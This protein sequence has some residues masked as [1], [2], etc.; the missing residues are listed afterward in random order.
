MPSPPA[1]LFRACLDLAVAGNAEFVPP[2]DGSG[3]GGFL[4]VR[5]VLF[6]AGPQLL[7][8]PP[9]EFV[10]AVYVAP[11]RPYH[12]AA[13]LD[14]LVLEDFD[15]AAPRGVGSAKLG[16]NYAPVWRHQ[17][18]AKEEG[19]GITL[20]LDSATRRFVEEFSTS[21]FLG[22]KVEEG[23]D[24][25][26]RKVLCV[27]ETPNAIRSATSDSLVR[28]AERDGWTVRREEVCD[29]ISFTLFFTVVILTAAS[30]QIPFDSLSSFDEVLAV[31]TAAAAVP[32]RSIT[33]KSTNEKIVFEGSSGAPGTESEG[34]HLARKMGAIQRGIA[35]DEF[36][37]CCRVEGAAGQ[38]VVEH[39]EKGV[40]E[41]LLWWS[42]K[43][44]Q[45]AYR[46]FPVVF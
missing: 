34:A 39:Q 33:R 3:G 23:K 27:P 44:L 18:R 17:A 16:G 19:F 26:R 35:E 8:A 22:V 14:A 20:H 37:W 15:R 30:A 42:W 46:G 29:R 9:D 10:F 28:L 5:P 6:G 41:S 25:E 21:G 1:P 4:Y 12:G 7:L 38:Q 32:I 2:A 31:G 36:G 13:A 40:E 45:T 43:L 24:G 11:G